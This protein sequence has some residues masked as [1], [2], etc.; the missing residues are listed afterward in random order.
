MPAPIEF[1]PQKK[2]T[3]GDQYKLAQGS[4]LGLMSP[5]NCKIRTQ[6]HFSSSLTAIPMQSDE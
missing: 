2:L 1:V 6:R 4:L 5:Q 3:A